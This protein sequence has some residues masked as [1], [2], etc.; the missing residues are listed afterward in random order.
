MSREITFKDIVGKK[1]LGLRGKSVNKYGKE[2]VPLEYI[3]FDDEETILEFKEQDS[4]DYHYHD[5]NNSARTI[6]LWT[7][8]EFWKLLKET[9]EESDG[10]YDSFF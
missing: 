10:G 2:F 4:Y 5:C 8:K 7:D 9:F 6:H 3:I 1:I